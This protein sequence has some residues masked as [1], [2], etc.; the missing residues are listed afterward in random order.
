MKRYLSAFMAII[1][2]AGFAFAG[3]KNRQILSIRDIQSD[4]YAYKGTIT[5]TGV[6]AD[7]SRHSIPPDVF[8]MVETLEAKLCK[9][10]GCAKFY[11]PVKYKG[12]HPKE[13]DEVNITGKITEVEG[14]LIFIADEVEFIRHLSF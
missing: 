11:L 6:V 7:K 4:P 3:S 1:L 12:E 13:W 10:T 5:V 8:L 9:R 2:L 14:N